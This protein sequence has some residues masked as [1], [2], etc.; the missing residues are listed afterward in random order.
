MKVDACIADEIMELNQ[1]G[2]VLNEMLTG[3]ANLLVLYDDDNPPERGVELR[4]DLD[5]K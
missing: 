1:K 4:I 2:V 5:I 3:N